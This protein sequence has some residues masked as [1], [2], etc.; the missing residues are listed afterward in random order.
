[1]QAIDDEK[2]AVIHDDAAEVTM[3]VGPVEEP[4]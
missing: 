1:M 2:P 3:P 4:W